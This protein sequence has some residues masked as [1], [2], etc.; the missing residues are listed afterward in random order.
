M[1]YRK[2]NKMLDRVL[3][4]IGVHVK[5][6]Y[7]DGREATRNLLD[8]ILD[9]G[10]MKEIVASENLPAGY[11]KYYEVVTGLNEALHDDKPEENNGA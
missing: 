11:Q 9:V 5:V 2:L 6:I 10:E 8:C 4:I 1:N 3:A 7:D